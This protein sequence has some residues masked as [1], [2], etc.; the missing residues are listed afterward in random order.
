MPQ[1]TC[2]VMLPGGRAGR[3]GHGPGPTWW[4]VQTHFF[5][6]FM[7]REWSETSSLQTDLTEGEGLFKDLTVGEGLFKDLT[8]G[9]GLFKELLPGRPA[10]GNQE[11]APRWRRTLL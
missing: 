11:V 3:T 4:E 6:D 2:K 7:L 10:G 1:S 5:I 8:E 9:E